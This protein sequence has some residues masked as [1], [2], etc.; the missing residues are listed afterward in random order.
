[1][2]QT[3]L[4]PNVSKTGITIEPYLVSDNL[5][6]FVYYKYIEEG[7]DVKILNLS[8]DWNFEDIPEASEYVFTPSAVLDALN[9][10]FVRECVEVLQRKY[11]NSKIL[12]GESPS[13]A[14]PDL[15]P[16]G[17][18]TFQVSLTEDYPSNVYEAAAYIPSL[19]LKKLQRENKSPLACIPTTL[20]CKNKCAFCANNAP[21]SR[22]KA[23]RIAEDIDRFLYHFPQGRVAFTGPLDSDRTNRGLLRDI[24]KNLKPNLPNE[25]TMFAAIPDISNEFF[26]TFKGYNVSLNVGIENFNETI[27]RDMKKITTRDDIE[28]ALSLILESPITTVYG[29]IIC[30]TPLDS[31]EIVRENASIVKR[32]GQLFKDKGKSL[33]V[34][35]EPL[36]VLPGTHYFET[37]DSIDTFQKGNYREEI[38]DRFPFYRN[39]GLREDVFIKYLELCQELNNLNQF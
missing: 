20:G 15:L 17:C 32:W 29:K 24:F 13:S 1:M 7:R 27:L 10:P 12:V 26:N 8:E 3:L 21:I 36:W 30:A 19:D 16:E 18:E 39:L 25:I 5:K 28:K 11:P 6:A 2:L 9:L 23:Q 33:R 37:R 31:E 34:S 14:P 35:F 38:Y 22:R 4:I